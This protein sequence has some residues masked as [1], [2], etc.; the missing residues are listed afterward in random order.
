MNSLQQRAQAVFV[1]Q[2][3]Y[4]PHLTAQA[5]G[6]VNL[7]G[8]HTDYNDGFVL[9]CA[10]N[11]RTLVCAAARADTLVRVVAVDYGDAIDEFD[12]SATLQTDTGSERGWVNYV[13]GMLQVAKMRGYRVA[14]LDLVMTGDVPQGAGLSSSASLEMALAES[15]SQLFAWSASRK[16]LALLGQAAENDFV[17]CQCGIM[18]QYISAMGREHQALLI[19]CRSLEARPVML[20]PDTQILIVNSNVRRGL[21]D[22]EYNSRRQQCETAASQLGVLALRDVS[23]AM[24]EERA[25]E[26]APLVRRRARHVVT[27]ND[28]VLQ[29][30]MAMN[31]ADLPLMARLMAESHVSMRDDFEITVPAI[32]T[33]VEM[34][35]DELGEAGG[36]RMTGG[37]FGGCVVALLPAA[38]L[39]QVVERIE[40]DYGN[41]TGLQADIHVCTAV[42]GMSVLD[43]RL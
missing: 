17:G 28:R 1:A 36:V 4:G 23:V 22:S 41:A 37:G 21:L 26:L 35:K 19:D 32:D 5:P 18:D 7:I 38:L 20:P 15:C 12:I 30:E 16:D 6:R 33:L 3:G 9:P 25:V 2:F 24:F 43:N 13:R 39:E 27:E 8:E 34:I 40:R 10:I 31:A 42:D 14:G 11:Y 29:A